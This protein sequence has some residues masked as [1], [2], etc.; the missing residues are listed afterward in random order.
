VVQVSALGADD[1]AQSRYHL[2]KKAADDVLRALPLRAAIVQPS[3]VYALHGASAGLFNRLAAMP[4]AALPRGG[5]MP[6][7]P[8]HLTDV[9]DGILSLL[10][11]SP[12]QQ[13][14][15][16]LVGPEAL[17]LREYLRE[18]RRALGIAGHLWVVPVPE[19]AFR[20]A[21]RV[22]GRMPGSSLD[23]E[24]AGMLLRGNAAP[25]EPFARLLG[26]SPRPA[27]SFISPTEAPALRTQA[28]LG[29]WLPGLRWTIAL[30]WIWTGLV[31]LGLYP[32][33]DSLALLG[34]V[35]LEG[36]PAQLALYGAAVLDLTLGVLTVGA[37]ARW[38]RSVWAAQF[39]LVSAYTVLISIFLPEYWL[40]PYGPIS[41]NLPLLAA[42]GL[43][44]ALEPVPPR[45]D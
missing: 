33:Q 34:R 28:V 40:H 39:I 4:V 11:D 17:T 21:A 5:A 45:T 24:T 20:W 14:T 18:I 9:V 25:A 19:L 2:S 12:S 23:P 44:W 6:L 43:C 13:R 1:A 42:I 37:P 26:R 41:K 38:R 31:S 35:G 32:V 7:Q 29:V 10:H 3:L 22:A 16:A 8:V 15:I 36:V 30:L 27:R